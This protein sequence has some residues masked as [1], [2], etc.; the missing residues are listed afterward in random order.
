M[1]QKLYRYEKRLKKFESSPHISL[2]KQDEIQDKVKRSVEQLSNDEENT[3]SAV[4]AESAP[5]PQ[6]AKYLTHVEPSLYCDN[7]LRMQSEHLVSEYGNT[8]RLQ[9]TERSAGDLKNFLSFKFAPRGD[10]RD[11]FYLCQECDRF[12]VT[13]EKPKAAKSAKNTWPS[14]ILAT[15]INEDVISIYRDKVWKLIPSQWR[16]WWVDTLPLVCEGYDNISIESPYPVTVD[17]TF[18]LVEWRTKINSQLLPEIEFACNKYMMPTILCPWGCNEF[19]FRTGFMSIDI[20]FQRFLRKV[21]LKLIHDIDKMKF[22]TYCRDDYIRGNNDYDCLL[23]NK[24]WT[25][26][27]SFCLR[28]NFGVQVMTCQDHDKGCPRCM[29]HPPRQPNHILSSKYSDQLCHAVIKPRTISMSKAQKYSNTYQMHEQRGNFNG[30]DTCSLTQYRN[31]KLLSFLLQENELRSL[32]GRADINALLT[33]LVKEKVLSPEIVANYRNMA[34]EET[35]DIDYLIQGATYVPIDVAVDMGIDKDRVVI[36]D[37]NENN[38]EYH[39]KPAF[40]KFLYPL[41]SCQNY[42]VHPHIIPTFRSV[43]RDATNTSMLWLLSG[44]LIRVQEIWELT[45]NMPLRQSKWNG[46]ILTYLANKTFHHYNAR[47]QRQDPFHVRYMSSDNKL[48]KKLVST[49]SLYTCLT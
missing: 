29:I 31:F 36:W 14:F 18:E 34:E 24:E 46:W 27:P 22:I 17:K 49:T 41:Q 33:Q 30:I 5:K 39:I 19:I 1:W 7:C 28:R 20:V 43:G 26:K 21:V 38:Q 12:L 40:P 48:V 10:E 13:E 2:S 37:E 44:L 42:G 47:V 15:L 16:H 6:C 23:L 11:A 3:E 32:K 8:F 35:L 45:H 9:F 4:V 25:V